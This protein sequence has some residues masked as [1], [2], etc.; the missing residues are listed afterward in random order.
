MREAI[1]KAAAADSELSKNFPE[2]SLD[3]MRKGKAPYAS[4]GQVGKHL[5]LELHHIHPIAKGGA[6]YDLDNLAIMTPRAHQDAH[7]GKN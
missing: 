3:N 6:V 2:I 4:S 5:T 7:K 1:W